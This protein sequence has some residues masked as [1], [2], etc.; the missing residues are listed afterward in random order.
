MLVAILLPGCK[1]FNVVK[2]DIPQ[3][4]DFLESGNKESVESFSIGSIVLMPYLAQNPK[5]GYYD[6]R[7]AAWAEKQNQTVRIQSVSFQHPIEGDFVS[8]V[9]ISPDVF[10]EKMKLFLSHKV[11]FGKIPEA[12]LKRL[13]EEGLNVQIRATSGEQTTWLEFKLDLLIQGYAAP[14]H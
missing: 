14:V 13:V 11:V 9:E 6:I 3:F 12:D 5:E 4:K 2:S 7:V 10:Q 1:T 8:P